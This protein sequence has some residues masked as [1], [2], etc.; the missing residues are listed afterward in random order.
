MTKTLE[1]SKAKSIDGWMTEPELIWLAERAG[2]HRVIC[3]IGSY[4]GR[5]TR[6][7]LDHTEGTVYAFD[8][9]R[10]PR[11]VYHFTKKERDQLIFRFMENV[12]APKRQKWGSKEG[13]LH[14]VVGNL[15]DTYRD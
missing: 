11:D 4:L 5:S 2:E 14:M 1:L 9:W 8:D 12:E 10:G 15:E 13:K 3:E 7:M 6:A